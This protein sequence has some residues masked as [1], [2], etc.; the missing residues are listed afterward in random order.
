MSNSP[1]VQVAREVMGA[2]GQERTRWLDDG[3]E[4]PHRIA[5]MVHEH[6]VPDVTGRLADG[7]A[8]AGVQV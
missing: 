1:G 3:S 6:A 2:V 8:R 4:H 5:L 7:L